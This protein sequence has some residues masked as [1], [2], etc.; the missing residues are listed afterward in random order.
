MLPSWLTT[1]CKVVEEAKLAIR[2]RLDGEVRLELL[3]MIVH[4]QRC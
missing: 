4:L 2:Q 3:T 1:L